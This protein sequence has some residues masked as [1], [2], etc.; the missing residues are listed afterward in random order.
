M[1]SQKIDSQ[2]S[3]MQQN[4]QEC[5]V[6]CQIY[7]ACKFLFMLIGINLFSQ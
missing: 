3:L 6:N 1:T 4:F 2:A 5:F 7:K